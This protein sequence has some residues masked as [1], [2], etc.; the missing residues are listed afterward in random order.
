VLGGWLAVVKNL[1]APFA[2]LIEQAVRFADEQ[3]GLAV[4]AKTGDMIAVLIFAPIFTVVLFLV[5]GNVMES[6]SKKAGK[7]LPKGKLATA[8]S[9]AEDT[10]K[11][12]RRSTATAPYDANYEELHEERP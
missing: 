1:F 6:L 4:P 10:K 9:Q 2:L 3:Y 11:T 12:A 5:F 8:Q 7:P